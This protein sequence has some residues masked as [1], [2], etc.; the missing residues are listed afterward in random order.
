MKRP[1]AHSNGKLTIPSC[2]EPTTY[3]TIQID[4]APPTGS[5]GC[6]NCA[7]EGPQSCCCFDCTHSNLCQVGNACYDEEEG[8]SVVCFCS[9]VLCQTTFGR[10]SNWWTRSICGTPFAFPD[11]PGVW[12]SKA[13]VSSGVMLP[14]FLVLYLCLG[15]IDLVLLIVVFF[16]VGAPLAPLFGL[17]YLFCPVVNK[18][19]DDVCGKQSFLFGNFCSRYADS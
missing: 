14:L 15:T 5:H 9:Q 12:L 7:G 18:T 13:V 1:A 17:T 2:V 16:G 4:D 19:A 11:P 8:L 6:G 10:W 3:R